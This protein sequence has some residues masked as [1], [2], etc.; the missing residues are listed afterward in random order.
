M[1]ASLAS[2]STL[3]QPDS[4]TGE[5]AMYVHAL[6]DVGPDRLDLVL[7]LLLGVREA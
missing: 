2:S 7:L 3:S 6:G 4:T 5:N 1:P